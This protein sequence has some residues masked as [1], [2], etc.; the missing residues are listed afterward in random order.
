[1]NPLV[2]LMNRPPARERLSSGLWKN[3]GH[4]HLLLFFDVSPGGG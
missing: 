4:Q 3:L 1:M 2:K